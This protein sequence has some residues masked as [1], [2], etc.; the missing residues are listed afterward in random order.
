VPGHAEVYVV[1][2]AAWAR[3]AVTGAPVPPTAQ[4]AEHMGRCV[5]QAIVASLAGD[6]V[7]AYRFSSRGHLTLLG[8]HTA[9]AEVG[10]LTVTG[11]L[12]WLLWHGYY[13]THIP[14][15]RN[16]VRLVADWILAALTGRETTELR[17]GVESPAERPP[18]PR[19]AEQTAPG[20]EPAVGADDLTGRAEQGIDTSR[21]IPERREV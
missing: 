16:R 4:G 19:A 11:L 5:A 21:G 7:P 9:V 12:A 10:P 14:C 13:V 17:L 20:H 15:W 6:H 3:D 8:R 1:G 2:D 18:A